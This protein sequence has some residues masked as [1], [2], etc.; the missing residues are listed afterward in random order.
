MTMDL[1]LRPASQAA[2]RG[3]YA[4]PAAT[5]GARLTRAVK[6]SAAGG[7]TSAQGASS[8]L[9]RASTSI[10]VTGL[11]RGGQR[12][13]GGTTLITASFGS[14]SGSGLG[15]SSAGLVG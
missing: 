12:G 8:S 7:A 5:T 2:A 4:G 9:R 3:G 6:A 1:P 11:Y 14:G 15:P 10:G 13:G